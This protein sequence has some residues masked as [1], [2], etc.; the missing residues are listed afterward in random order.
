MCLKVRCAE[1]DLKLCSR[2][3]HTLIILLY[4]FPVLG[5]LYVTSYLNLV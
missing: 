4:L 2:P 1:R 5:G 3:L